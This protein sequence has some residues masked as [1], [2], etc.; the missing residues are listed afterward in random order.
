M[1]AL[2]RGRLRAGR[3]RTVTLL[4]VLIASLYLTTYS[5]HVES[6][7]ARRLF[8]SA[9]SLVDHGD[10]LLDLSVWQFPPQDFDVDNPLP[11]PG[12]N[13]EPLQVIAVAALYA[14]AKVTPFGLV[15]TVY[16]LNVIVGA[17]AGCILYLYART[18]GYRER[19]AIL[20]ALLFA[21]CTVMWVY[22]KWLFREP[23]LLLFLLLSALLLERL[24]R[25]GYRSMPLVI[26]LVFSVIALIL[27][28][29][30][31]ALA[32]PALL[33]IAL[34][35]LNNV[36][37]RRLLI[38]IG[39]AL[40]LLIAVFGV[41][42]IYGEAVGL[43]ERYNVLRLISRASPQY[44]IMALHTYLISPGGSIWGTSPIL[45]LAL[46]GLV[47]F[48][49]RRQFRYPVAVTLLL[50]AFVIGYAWLNGVH[51]FGGLS[52]PPRFL[53]QVIPF[54][55]IGALPVIDRLANG[56]SAWWWVAA[57]LI[58]YS[59]WVQITGASLRLEAYVDLL[60]TEANR[61]IEWGGGLNVMRYLR[62]FLI[63]SL[64]GVYPADNAWTQIERGGYIAAFAGVI[65][66]SALL[67]VRRA[68]WWSLIAV[69]FALILV[70][71]LLD[72]YRSDA[73]YRAFDD[74]LFA[75][76]PV[77]ESETD[78]GDIIL[79]SSPRYETFFANAGK[80]WDAGRVIALSQQPGD[81]PSE[82]QPAEIE[83]ENPAALLTNPTIQL[84]T[85]LAVTH[86]RLWLLND[87]SPDI[88]WSVRPVERFLSAR[89]YPLNYRRMGDFAWLV[90]YSTITAP[91]R[92]AYRAPELTTDLVFDETLRLGGYVLPAGTV[93]APG[94][95]VP[96]TLY[97]LTDV[98]IAGNYSIGFYVRA[99]NGS[100][101]AQFDSAP[102]GGFAPT[103]TWIPGTPVWDN[104]AVVLPL[105][106]PAGEYVLWVKVYENTGAVRD[107]P[108][109]SGTAVDGV[110]GVLPTRIQVR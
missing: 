65:V 83:A 14:V 68:R 78:P 107:L 15:H 72:L 9:S 90:E 106:L 23:L 19:T 85:N 63:P 8:D 67:L 70:V 34:P 93:Y 102:D 71:G 104:R 30:S 40:G 50:L 103:S 38:G 20:A 47:L 69:A 16:L 32:F 92:Y 59:L 7:D 57:S 74:A 31:A 2:R 79:L 43:G 41:L 5:A 58:A 87:G 33:V 75:T 61:L 60:P 46:P 62:P 35:A 82:T 21:A 11:L 73:R 84:L 98:P 22:S 37:W 26:G 99:M 97:W 95:V 44:F 53:V 52:F 1:P 17:L 108:V 24:R 48:V 6:G 66:V 25:G 28:K 42:A 13:I 12:G 91:E 109:T 100:P 94:A 101:V 88:W 27:T 86:D 54:L 3:L 80:L 81:R 36:R 110:I 29:A 105:D 56:R 51:W 10:M 89:Y 64:W 45:L 39:I 55:V 77:L 49:R 96:I 4:F 76:L 18:L